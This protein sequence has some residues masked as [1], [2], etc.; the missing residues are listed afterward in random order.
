MIVT[1]ATPIAVCGWQPSFGR[2]FEEFR[3]LAARSDGRVAD[4]T[5][6]QRE[7]QVA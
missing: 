6:R 4:Q 2:N 5:R 1:E 7:A 3:H